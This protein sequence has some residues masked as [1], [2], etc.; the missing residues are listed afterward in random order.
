[1][2][3]VQANKLEPGMVLAKNII[4][5]KRRGMMLSKGMTLN[6]SYIAHI[7]QHGYLGAYVVDEMS[8]EVEA[9]D[10][11][12]EQLF[13]EGIEAVF[14]ADVGALT[15]VATKMVQQISQKK[16]LRVDLFDLRS[17][18]DYTYH[19]SVNVAVY[20]SVIGRKLG[21]SHEDLELLSMA[22]LSHDLGKSKIPEMILNKP[23]RLDEEEYD[24]IK[25]HSQFSYDV[26]TEDHH[27]IPARV[28][29]AVLFH[30]E[31]ED[32]SGYPNGLTGESIPLFAK[33]I[34]A[35]DVFDALT[36][37]RPYKQPYSPAEAY[38][39]ML[40][41]KG[42]L[43][44]ENVVN[45]MMTCIPAYPPGLDV[46]LSNGKEALVVGNTIHAM[47]PV[48]KLY[49]TGEIVNLYT[50]AEYTN[51]TIIASGIMQADYAQKVEILNESRQKGK[52]RKTR[53]MVVDNNVN[54]LEQVKNALREEYI[55]DAVSTGVEVINQISE[56][57]IPD[58]LIIS[59]ELN[60]I[61]GM[62]TVKTIRNA[63]NNIPVIFTANSIT[64]ENIMQCKELGAVDCILKPFNIH[65]L[66]ERVQLAMA[67]IEK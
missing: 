5:M 62:S 53:I 51:I 4:G 1:M 31:N 67:A 63:G 33:I 17:Y 19:H 34:H 54:V 23:G 61:S 52:A 3:F 36:S 37:K 10:V 2:K 39:Y 60:M 22:A 13:S 9:Q 28:R 12:D 58:L 50:D 26:L 65:Y 29:M 45:Q 47:R 16:S 48:V 64:R 42:T 41:S 59:T 32:G 44:D 6:E 11:I 49:E 24:A 21:L 38:E 7:Q 56:K 20:A 8:K 30:H 15:N 18:D 66:I 25:K 57:K 27:V 35:V 46:T 14:Q 43:F 40:A 55:V